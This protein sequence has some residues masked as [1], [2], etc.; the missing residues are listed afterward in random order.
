[1]FGLL[2]KILP[3]ASTGGKAASTGAPE[4]R[5]ERIATRV[6]PSTECIRYKNQ[7]NA[8]LAEGKLGDAA[9][10]Y[11]R[12]LA[13]E[14]NYVAACINLG[15]V[16]S[17]QKSFEDAERFLKQAARIDPT[18]A[19][20]H[21][22]LGQIARECGRLI[23]AVEHLETALA[24]KADFEFAYRDLHELH[25]QAG[26]NDEAR[27]VLLRAIMVNPEWA[28]FH[29]AL[30]DRYMADGRFEE[31]IEHYLAGM[32]IWPD[33]ADIHF[34]L[35]TA[36]SR[37][38]AYALAAESYERSLSISPGNVLA[39]GNLGNA[40]TGLGKFDQ[41][42]EKFNQAL[43]INPDIAEIYNNRGNTLEWQGRYAE[44]IES[45]AHAVSLDPECA[46]AHWNEALAHLRNGDLE[47]GWKKFE[48]RWKATVV[49]CRTRD[50][51]QPYWQG[52]ESLQ[53]KTIL[54]HLEQGYGDTI[55]FCRYAKLVAAQ[56]ATVIM[57][58]PPPLAPLLKTVEGVHRLI[59]NEPLSHLDYHC[60]LMS[61]PRAFGTNL[62]TVPADV[63]YIHSTPERAAYWKGR[64]GDSRL[65]RVGLV[66]SGNP[67]HT[68]DH[69]RSLQLSQIVRI[70][71]IVSERAQFI[72]LQKNMRPDDRR[73]LEER[74]DIVHLGDELNDF[75]D[76]AGLI[77]NLDLLIS[78]DTSV[79]H[80]AGAM[81]KPVWILLPYLPDWRWLRERQDSPW[82]PSAR[83]FR[84]PAV[85]D[86]QGAISTLA[87]ELENSLE[88]FRR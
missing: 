36:Y 57:E 85:N 6:E 30:A 39:I 55:Q 9:Q 56:G 81:G 67:T 19:D 2:K 12:A 63:P 8:L 32:K 21:Y 18:L 53:G 84:Q 88:T 74:N 87:V 64:L 41:A 15:Y 3:I 59:Y 7:G 33:N 38:N 83:L 22:M 50:F 25:L 26:Q 42:I 1:M 17:E 66:W 16:L 70:A 35:G 46:A 69:N 47:K 4:E 65:P 28:A 40:L 29:C 23:E 75:G 34:R 13:I 60:S 51:T 76:T 77:A 52:Q 86:W 20:P 71:D 72:S 78:V 43:S 68:N 10:C 80:L 5:M 61:L 49:Q 45:Y 27:K 24:L 82:Y 14:P 11:R 62:D 31:A 58:S 37:T 54:L 48:W 79:A 44:A 73:F